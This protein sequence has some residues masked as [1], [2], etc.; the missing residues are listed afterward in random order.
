MPIYSRQ[1]NKCEK[2][3][4]IIRS[5]AESDIPPTEDE[6]GPITDCPHE[7]WT[8]IITHAP[9]KAYAPGWGSDRKGSYGSGW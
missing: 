2:I 8:N 7:K 6:I 1:C 9:K 5:M 4:E 3:I